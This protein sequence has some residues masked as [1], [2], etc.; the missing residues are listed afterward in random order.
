MD[1]FRDWIKFIPPGP[2]GPCHHVRSL[3]YRQGMAVLGPKQLLDLYPGHF[4]SFTRLENLQIFNLSLR[5]FTPTS[6]KKAFGPVGSFIRTLVVKDVVL[7]LN[8]LLMFLV[9]FPRLETLHIG[10]NLTIVPEKK[11][12]P[13]S[14]PN[15]R[16]ELVLVSMGSIHRPFVLE[17]SKLPLRYSELDVEF[18]WNS[19]TLNAIA[20]LILTCSPT[21]ERLTLRYARALFV[22]DAEEAFPLDLKLCTLL[23]K[24]TIQVPKREAQEHLV[25][26][27]GTIRSQNLETIEFIGPANSVQPSTWAMVDDELCALVDRLEEDGWKG[28]L[29]A[30]IHHSELRRD[31]FEEGQLLARFRNKGKVVESV[32]SRLETLWESY[33]C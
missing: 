16:G 8:S 10:D 22:E 11:K 31:T 26:L 33:W 20:H 28:E 13:P 9:H 14:L 12:Q 32:D 29:R 30:V 23:R 1:H 18:R 6:M 21:L 19:E 27:L 15:L 3:T 25:R 24:V 5:R 4:T 17:L 7:T 2:N